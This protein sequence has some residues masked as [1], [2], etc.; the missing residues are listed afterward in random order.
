MIDAF[1]SVIWG[2]DRA[3]SDWINGEHERHK[4]MNQDKNG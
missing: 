2:L 3:Y 1:I 4:R